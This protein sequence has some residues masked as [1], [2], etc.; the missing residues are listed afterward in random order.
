[1]AITIPTMF[2][3][4]EAISPSVALD[5]DGALPPDDALAVAG[6]L[7]V[8]SNSQCID[9]RPGA[10]WPWCDRRG[11]VADSAWQLPATQPLP[12]HLRVRTCR[13]AC[14][15]GSAIE[16]ARAGEE[17]HPIP[18]S[19]SAGGAFARLLRQ[20]GPVVCD[21]QLEV[22]RVARPAASGWA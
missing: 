15:C 20:H 4:L 11:I 1:M 9:G 16:Q 13:S 14:G 17:L 5:T 18:S 12:R 22:D 8:D 3:D 21:Q 2:G 19:S 7:A 10:P 6:W